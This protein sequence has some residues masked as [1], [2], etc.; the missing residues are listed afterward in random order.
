MKTE[1]LET[2]PIYKASHSLAKVNRI[3]Q[4]CG[5]DKLIPLAQDAETPPPHIPHVD[6][7]DVTHEEYNRMFDVKKK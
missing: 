4:I 6:Y 7:I 2:N 5:M 3:R 1:Y